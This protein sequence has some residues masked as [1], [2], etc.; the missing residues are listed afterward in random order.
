MVSAT[1]VWRLIA[2]GSAA[3]LMLWAS[4]MTALP[5]VSA[6]AALIA[7][8]RAASLSTLITTSVPVLPSETRLKVMPV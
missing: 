4:V 8:S 1:P 7:R 3:S 5:D 6:S 2:V